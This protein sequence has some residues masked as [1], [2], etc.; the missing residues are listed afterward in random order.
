MNVLYLCPDLGIP[1][2]GRK[3]G[4]VHVRE[5]VA[6]LGRAG[7]NVVLAAQILNKSPWEIPAEVKSPVLQIDPALGVT[8]A[9]PTLKEFNRR[10]GVESSLP[11]EIRRILYNKDFETE[12]KRRFENDPPDFIYERASLYGTAGVSLARELRRPV[13]LELNAPLALEQKAYRATGLGDLAAQAERWALNHADSIVVVSAE[14]KEHVASQGVDPARIYV[15]PNAVNPAVFYPSPPDDGVRT[16]WGFDTGPVIGF[17][18]G[19]RPWH[20]VEVLPELLERLTH[21]HPGIR[22]VVAGDGPLRGKLEKALDQRGLR[23]RAIITGPL[24]HEEIPSVI[25]QFDVA[26]AP[27]PAPDHRFYFS[28]LKLFEYMA[29]GIAVVAPALGQIVQLIQDGQTGL[30][31]PP[32]DLELLAAQCERLLSDA[33]LRQTL[34]QSAAKLIQAQYSWD[35][36]ASRVAALARSLMSGT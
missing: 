18:G 24:A 4:A 12:L 27:Y 26:V 15:L 3:G 10:L 23:S 25:R 32:G 17:V 6:A 13:I 35:H 34:G 1:V 22:L 8:T 2:L 19:L 36:N 11:G 21:R 9:I 16:G 14:L 7:H 29:C 5:M 33:T 31:Y 30:L 20:G 28:P